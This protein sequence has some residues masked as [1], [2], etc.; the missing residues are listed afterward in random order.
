MIR[1][2]SIKRRTATLNQYSRSIVCMDAPLLFRIIVYALIRA[3]QYTDRASAGKNKAVI[4]RF[5]PVTHSYSCVYTSVSG[6]RPYFLHSR[7]ASFAAVSSLSLRLSMHSMAIVSRVL[8]STG[9]CVFAGAC[10][11]LTNRHAAGVPCGQCRPRRPARRSDGRHRFSASPWSK[12]RRAPA[13]ST[14]RFRGR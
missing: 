10:G 2:V 6:S 13:R 12:R 5:L 3:N 9:R 8:S 7:S 4:L 11:R 1:R 14:Y